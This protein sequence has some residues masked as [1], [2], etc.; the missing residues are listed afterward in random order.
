MPR[1]AQLRSL[2]IARYPGPAE[3][4]VD[5]INCATPDC[6]RVQMTLHLGTSAPF[7]IVLRSVQHGLPLQGMALLKASAGRGAVTGRRH[8]I[9]DPQNCHSRGMMAQASDVHCV[10]C[11]LGRSEAERRSDQNERQIL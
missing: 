1:Q 10:A 11:K 2:T 4:Q 5:T 8:D 7:E 9:A 6:G 3:G